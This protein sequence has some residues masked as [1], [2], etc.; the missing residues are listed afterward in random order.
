MIFVN[1]VC[2]QQDLGYKAVKQESVRSHDPS[3]LSA[4]SFFNETRSE[5]D[6]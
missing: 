2:E 3:G 5:H 4:L 1:F 6:R